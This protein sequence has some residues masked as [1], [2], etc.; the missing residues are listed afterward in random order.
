MSTGRLISRAFP[1]L[2]RLHQVAALRRQVQASVKNFTSSVWTW[3]KFRS[4]SCSRQS[5]FFKEEG[6]S[7]G[8]ENVSPASVV[9]FFW[10]TSFVYSI[11]N[12]TSEPANKNSNL[13]LFM[14]NLTH[15]IIGRIGHWHLYS[16]Y[17][18]IYIISYH[19]SSFWSIWY[20]V[21]YKKK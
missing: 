11:D 7:S 21:E 3:V 10:N 14:N 15:N 20:L 17:F 13:V 12:L 2:T 16:F 4:R 5:K 18:S 8:S 6:F 19:L 9:I 1:K